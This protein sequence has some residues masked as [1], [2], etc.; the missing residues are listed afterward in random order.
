M[1]EQTGVQKGRQVVHLLYVV[2]EEEVAVEAV[3]VFVLIE[4]V[5]HASR[6]QC[7]LLTVTKCSTPSATPHPTPLQNT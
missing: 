4:Q 3:L 5:L 7:L 1:L 6:V 2:G